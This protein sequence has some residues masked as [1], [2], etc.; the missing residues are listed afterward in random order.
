M[1]AQ[2]IY[3]QRLQYLIYMLRHSIPGGAVQLASKLGCSDRTLKNYMAK[4]RKD[5]FDIKYCKALQR[6]VLAEE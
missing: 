4:L 6:Y 3:R 1:T 5:G 2:H